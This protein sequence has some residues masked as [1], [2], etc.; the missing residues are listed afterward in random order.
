MSTFF[1]DKR[2]SWGRSVVASSVLLAVSTSVLLGPSS[3][4]AQPRG[5]VGAGS[6]SAPTKAVSDDKKK[7]AGERFNRGVK[8]QQDGNLDAAVIEFERAYELS[9]STYQ[10]LYNIAVVYR[11]KGDR[12]SS[13]RAFE[14]FLV[15]GKDNIDARRRKDVETEIAK[16]RDVVATVIIRTPVVGADITLDDL[17]IGKTPL[18]QPLLVNVGRHKIEASHEGYRSDTQF[19]TLAGRDNRTVD[20]NLKEIK[21]DA[22]P[23]ATTVIVAPP[24]T[25]TATATATMTTPPPPKNESSGY[26]GLG[27]GLGIAGVVGL[28]IGTGFG[29]AAKSNWD[30]VKNKCTPACQTHDQHTK[31]DRASSFATASTLGFGLGGAALL[32]GIIL[33]ATSGS[34]DDSKTG[35]ATRIRVTPTV[36]QSAG[37]M[38]LGGA[39]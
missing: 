17:P 5:A 32:A 2:G 7:E 12:A 20:L 18:P 39:F 27:I 36:S 34:S 16:L 33:I 25:S 30:D 19:V 37:G 3:S 4:Q 31:A 38:I 35:S 23:P 14:R 13:L 6:A 8:L 21:T 9:P 28:G 1:A 11:D 29:L 22:P 26:R 24:P 15:E 10:V